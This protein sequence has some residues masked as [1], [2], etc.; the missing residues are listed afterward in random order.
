L[1][2]EKEEVQQELAMCDLIM[3]IAESGG[4]IEAIIT[5]M[6]SRGGSAGAQARGCFALGTLAKNTTNSAEIVTWGGVE[7]VLAAM[8]S[9]GDS[10]AVQV[11][12]CKAL[13]NLSEGAPG[14]QWLFSGG[15]DTDVIARLRDCDAAEVLRGVRTKFCAHA[16]I[17]MP[18]DRVLKKLC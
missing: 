1:Q 4:G 8:R 17:T 16:R 11:Q 2:R 15:N 5:A 6:R 18:V 7:A 14:A 10:A 3:S 12:G 9:H 13:Y